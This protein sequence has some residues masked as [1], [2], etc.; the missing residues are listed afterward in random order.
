M[1]QLQEEITRER[2]I[3]VDAAWLGQNDLLRLVFR[4][5]PDWRSLSDW[6]GGDLRRGASAL[7]G[8][9]VRLRTEFLAVIAEEVARLRNSLDDCTIDPTPE[10]YVSL[11]RRHLQTLRIPLRGGSRSKAFRSWESS[12][13]ATSISRMSSSFR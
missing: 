2:R 12:R 11:L 10:I 13:R 7:R 3:A 9:D 5:A 1:K 4:A 8:D 6:L